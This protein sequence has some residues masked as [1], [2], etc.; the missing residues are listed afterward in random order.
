MQKM[1]RSV[2]HG[3][4]VYSQGEFEKWCRGHTMGGDNQVTEGVY[5][6]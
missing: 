3:G 1:G 5:G 2:G 4:C 6:T